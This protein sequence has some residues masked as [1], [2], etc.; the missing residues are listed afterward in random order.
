M[1]FDLLINL[2]TLFMLV[3]GGLALA[4]IVAAFIGS[5]IACRPDAPDLDDW[6]G[7]PWS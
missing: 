1:P 6:D 2:C 5:C 3:M 4:F 7:G